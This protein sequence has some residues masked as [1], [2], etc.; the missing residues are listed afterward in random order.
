MLLAIRERA[1]GW[2]AWVIV[3][4]ISIPFALWGIQEYLGIGGE[5]VVIKVNDRE[6]TERE[7]DSNFQRFRLQLR[8]QLG[9][10]YRA[11]AID[12][13]L[14][15]QQVL[16]SMVRSEVLLQAARD[17]NMQVSDGMLRQVIS[18][19]PAFQRA[20]KFDY[21][22]Y[23]SSLRMQGMNPELFA[24]RMRGS[25]V[26]EQLT[27]GISNSEFTTQSELKELVRLKE[28]KREISY[29]RFPV[30]A[31]RSDDPV[32]DAEVKRYYEQN[33]AGFMAPERV[34]LEY[35][36]LNAEVLSKQIKTDDKTL[37]R[38]LESH[39]NEFQLPEE[40]RAAHIL[41]TIKDGKEAEAREKAEKLLA[42][43]KG[44]DDF[45]VV[46]KAESEDPGSASLGGDLG[47]FGAGVMDP[48][49]EKATFALKLGEISPLV[50]S[51]FGFHII[52]L[53][54]KRGGGKADLA[55]VRDRVAAAYNS[56]EAQK[57]FY[58]YAER[59]A[60]L[61]YETPDSL[62]PVVEELSIPLKSTDW[63]T[64]AGGEGIL[65]SPKVTG[66]AFSDDVLSGGNNS[67]AVELNSEH[68]VIVRVTAHEAAAAKALGDVRD[69]IETTLKQERAIKTATKAGQSAL[70]QVGEGAALDSL[71]VKGRV[72][73]E[74]PKLLDRYSMDAPRG[75]LQ[76]AF[77]L[78]HP[79]E[80]KRSYAGTELDSGDY[81]VV[82]VSKVENGVVAQGAENE[83]TAKQLARQLGD[84]YH[85][86]YV[87]A[88]QQRADIEYLQKI[89]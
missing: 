49:F 43:I 20:G 85:E 23:E 11:G 87:D 69:E 2:V 27:N 4:F 65:K 32:D 35:V 42:G 71:V 51:Q 72:V 55:A 63:V 79:V 9:D 75:I 83:S 40:Y 47:F 3:I 60:D 41:V 76:K 84:R 50:R 6:I 19:V 70:A 80:G 36:E 7:L 88:L 28:Q 34:K 68:I 74:Q 77:Q 10:S 81:A 12:D 33:Q 14:L 22:S 61:A 1:Q 53:S 31:Y 57:L 5:P 64:R 66:A 67:E 78:P 58:E 52:R 48:A 89:E 21:A 15:K 26:V 37:Q 25:M 13:K 18:A 62:D 8:E 44:G 73:L 54:E 16:D 17:Q 30:E 56:E 59:M 45:A 39:S 86:L 46:A 29:L 82:A 38:Y 24:Q